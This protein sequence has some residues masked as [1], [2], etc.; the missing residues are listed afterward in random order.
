L[1]LTRPRRDDE[2]GK[3]HGSF[4]RSAEDEGE[5]GDPAEAVADLG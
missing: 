4:Q 1:A 2:G 3:S 5:I